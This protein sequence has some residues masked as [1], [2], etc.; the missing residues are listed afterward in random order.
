MS[1]ISPGRAAAL[2]AVAVALLVSG[3]GRQDGSG[4]SGGHGR[5]GGPGAGVPSQP[6]TADSLDPDAPRYGAEPA[7][8]PAQPSRDCTG[9]TGTLLEPGPVD[10]AM[11]LR[12][13]TVW[14]THCGTGTYRLDGYPTLQVLA[15]D[16]TAFDVHSLRGAQAVTTGV[17]DPGPHP[18]TLRHGESATAGVV[19]RNTYANTTKAPV[20]GARLQVLPAPGRPARTIA[21]DG[22]IDLGSTGRIGTTAWRKAAAESGAGRPTGPAPS[23]PAS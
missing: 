21:P 8:R 2:G 23:T 19:W 22:G 16:G 13:M 20:E 15:E 10:S 9:R 12:A 6:V 4:G 18:V 14:L 5:G 7:E 3:C 17:E 11:G 1:R